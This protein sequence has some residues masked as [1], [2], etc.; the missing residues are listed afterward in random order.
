MGHIEQLRSSD[1]RRY[2]NAVRHVESAEIPFQEDEI[3]PSIAAKILGR[4]LPM[5]HSY[6][7]PVADYVELNLRC[8]NDLVFLAHLWKLGRKTMLDSDGREHYVD[9]VIKTRADLKNI[10]YPDLDAIRRHIEE[11]LAAIG[12]TGLG[13][14]YTPSQAPFIVTTA[15]GYADYYEALITGPGFIHEFQKRVEDFCLRE[16]ELALSYPIDVVQFGAVLCAKNG[17]MFSRAMR[18]E[19]EYPSL[20]R[21]VAMAKA[22]GVA[23]SG[24]FDGDNTALMPELIDIGIEVLNPVERCGGSQDIYRLKELYGD[25]LAFHGNIDLTGV[26]VYGTPEEVRRDVIEHIERLAVGGGY[27]CAS[28]HNITEAVPIENFCAMRDAVQTYRFRA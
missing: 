12:G 20:R 3:D 14:K 2:L 5:V 21:R 23:V 27:I 6:E 19:F 18:E 17:P 10:T 7:L 16:L 26:L 13:L 25:K 22:K 11:V 1:K 24:H 9:G 28:S 15:M 4:R 8:G